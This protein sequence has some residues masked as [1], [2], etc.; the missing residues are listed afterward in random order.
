[1]DGLLELVLEH[2]YSAEEDTYGRKGFWTPVFNEYSKTD[3]IK[4][5]RSL[6]DAMLADDYRL[7][8]LLRLT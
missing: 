2:W 4:I 3:D 8:V 7:A 1:M 5:A 6:A